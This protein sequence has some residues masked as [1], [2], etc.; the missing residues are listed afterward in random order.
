MRKQRAVANLSRTLDKR[1]ITVTGPWR[2]RRICVECHEWCENN[3]FPSQR[4]AG[5][6]QGLPWDNLSTVQ[7]SQINKNLPQQTLIA[8]RL[9][10]DRVPLLIPTQLDWKCNKPLYGDRHNSR[11]D[12][13]TVVAQFCCVT[14]VENSTLFIY[15]FLVTS[16][17]LENLAEQHLPI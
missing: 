3:Q 2:R 1:C 15:L 14:G 7:E 12:T 13:E 11:P 4:S 16:P 17:F 8:Q 10:V 6:P 5:P 9:H